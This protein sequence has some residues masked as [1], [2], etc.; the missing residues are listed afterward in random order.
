MLIDE[1]H[2]YR[3]TQG[4]EIAYMIRRFLDKIGALEKGKLKIIASSASMDENNKGF[5][6]DFFGV[7]KTSFEIITNP[8]I[9]EKSKNIDEVNLKQKLIENNID[10]D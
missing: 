6:E 7:D 1:I 2:T 10:P 8:P 4:T 9:E 5:L 3:G